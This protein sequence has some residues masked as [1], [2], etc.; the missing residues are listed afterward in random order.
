MAITRTQTQI[1]WSAYDS[2]TI[3]SAT[4]TFSDAFTLDDTAVLL[5]IQLSADN[6][7]TPADGDTAKFYI[8]WSTGD[9][10]GD[11]GDDY[12]TDE[13]VQFIGTLDTYSTNTPGE[14]PARKTIE[15]P[16]AA[17][18][19]KIG[20]ECANAATRNIVVRSRADEQRAA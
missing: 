7:G 9:I 5:G 10:L 2:I 19:F 1:Q 8:A 14:D 12:D 20:V 15:V 4:R 6:Q 17:K 16:I 18:K 13:H 3:S 11:A